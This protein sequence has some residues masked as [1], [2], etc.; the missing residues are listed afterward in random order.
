MDSACSCISTNERW[1]GNMLVALREFQA[2]CC[3]AGESIGAAIEGYQSLH[4]SYMSG[5]HSN[6]KLVLGKP[7]KEEEIP[8]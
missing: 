2:A 4:N 1:L 7:G 3:I 6:T 5:L 8:A